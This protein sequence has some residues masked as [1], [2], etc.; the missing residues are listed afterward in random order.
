MINNDQSISCPVCGTKI[1]IDTTQLL[2]GIQFKC[3]NQDCDVSIG[4]HNDSKPIVE[5][6]MTKLN[7]LKENLNKS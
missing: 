2:L 1:P 5:K 6:T 3:P 7:E 4:L